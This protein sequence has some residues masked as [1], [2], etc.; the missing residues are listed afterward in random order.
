MDIIIREIRGSGAEEIS[1]VKMVP[2]RPGSAHMRRFFGKLD[3]GTPVAYSAL[4]FHHSDL[5]EVPRKNA[6]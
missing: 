6:P 1:A 5:L 3:S 4:V 2:I